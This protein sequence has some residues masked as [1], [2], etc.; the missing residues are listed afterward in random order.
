M[1]L[2]GSEEEITQLFV[3]LTDEAEKPN[4]YNAGT[5]LEHEPWRNTFFDGLTTVRDLLREVAPGQIYGISL[6][7]T[8][9]RLYVNR[10]LL[11]EITGS[12]AMPTE[13]A[14]LYAL[15]QKIREYNQR[16]GSKIIP[17]ASCRGYAD[18]IFDRIVGSQVQKFLIDTKTH[19]RSWGFFKPMYRQTYT[20]SETP[21][22]LSSL[23]LMSEVAQLLTPGYEQFHPEDAIAAYLQQRSLML[24]AGSWDY[25]VLPLRLARCPCPCLP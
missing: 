15:G 10:D 5:H 4:P 25:A 19:M 9:M 22:F 14:D 18:Y 23:E 6:Q 21:E 24:V 17:I 7:T 20:Y 2:Y 1:G 11:I 13:Y 3:P 16:T 12:D 8:S